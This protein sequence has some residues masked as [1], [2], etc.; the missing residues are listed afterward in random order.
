MLMNA[1]NK[2][3]NENGRERV[4]SHDHKFNS[5]HCIRRWRAQ[6]KLGESWSPFSLLLSTSH[7]VLNEGEQ[8]RDSAFCVNMIVPHFNIILFY[9]SAES[10]SAWGGG[11]IEGRK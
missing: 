8:V 5:A 7:P 9:R 2:E 3:A 6:S 11:D 10:Q 4:I 1:K